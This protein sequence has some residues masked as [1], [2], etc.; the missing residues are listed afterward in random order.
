MDKT[1]QEK[2]KPIKL[3]ITDVDGVLTSGHLVFSNQ[4]LMCKE[5]HVH[6]GLGLQLLKKSGVKIAAVTTCSAELNRIRL[7]FLE[8]DDILLGQQDKR[9]AYQQLKEK[10]Q[11][12]DHEIAYIGDDLPDL[13][14]IIRA[15]LGVVPA[16]AVALLKSHA[17]WQTSAFGGHGAVRELCEHIMRVQNTFDPLMQSY[18][19]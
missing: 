9:A 12:G 7:E 19:S 16:N 3:L 10:Y 15:G 13:P 1:L 2:T 6:D 11:L 14:Q 8:F 5:F 18:L 4:G 17:D